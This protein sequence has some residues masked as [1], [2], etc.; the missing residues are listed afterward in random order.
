MAAESV[1]TLESVRRAWPALNEYDQ[2]AVLVDLDGVVEGGYLMAQEHDNIREV[3]QALVDRR[4]DERRRAEEDC[5][6]DT[7]ALVREEITKVFGEL[8]GLLKGEAPDGRGPKKFRARGRWHCSLCHEVGH[9]ARKCP[10]RA[11]PGAAA[12]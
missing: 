12:T 11:D 5:L 9:T 8:K 7:R 4:I 2:L 10:K 6:P 1:W 3:L